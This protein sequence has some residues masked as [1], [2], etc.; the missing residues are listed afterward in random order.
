VA[1]DNVAEAI[2]SVILKLVTIVTV[3]HAGLNKTVAAGGDAA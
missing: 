3:F 2:T 1:D